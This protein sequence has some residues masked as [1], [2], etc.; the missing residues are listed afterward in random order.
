[1]KRPSEPDQ[2][3]KRIAA[4]EAALHEAVA[5]FLEDPGAS[6]LD[7]E[8]PIW[9]R[10]QLGQYRR[11]KRLLDNPESIEAARKAQAIE[12]QTPLGEIRAL[13]SVDR[14]YPGIFWE[15][16]GQT[17]ALLDAGNVKDEGEERHMLL[18]VWTHSDYGDPNYVIEI[19]KREEQLQ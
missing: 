13:R 4:L 11:W 8:Q 19:E 16:Q 15:W 6:D 14:D 5:G 1:M 9:I 7:D 10:A 17:V 3:D 2:R 18:R 12:V